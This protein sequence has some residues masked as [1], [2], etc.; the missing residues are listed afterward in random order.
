[1]PGLGQRMAQGADDQPADRP[2][3]AEPD[4]RLGRMDV[5][6][7]FG[8][9]N[10][11]K[12][13][14]ERMAV[15]GQEIAIGAAHGPGHQAILDRPAVD[16]EILVPRGSPMQRRHADMAGQ[17]YAV[18]HGV[19][20]HRIVGKILAQ[21]RREPRQPDIEHVPGVD[22]Q[23]KQGAFA[24]AAQAETDFRMRH[25]QPVDRVA[26]RLLLAALALEELEPRRRGVEQVEH[27]DLGAAGHRRRSGNAAQAAVN[28][29]RPARIGVRLPGR[30]L[31]PADR[32]DRRQRLAAEAEGRNVDEIVARQ[33]AGGVPLHGKRQGLAP[34][35][36]AVV[37]HGD[38]APAAVAHDRID[39][40]RTGVD[41]VLDQFLD[42]GR[43]AL[44]HLAR[45]NPVNN[46]WW[47][48]TNHS[49]N[50]VIQLSPDFERKS[51]TIAFAASTA[52]WV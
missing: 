24:V 7:H 44:D 16:E 19:D 11:E 15:A 13:G 22:R 50:N 1:M 17:P 25:R 41:R 23:R 10:I 35:A 48:E 37:G 3:I 52:G 49:P 47:K 46:I 30:D 5:H 27:L 2:G 18:A 42:D 33:L 6:V 45:G 28:V 29:D 12:Q 39:P 8:R 31:E 36:A 4:F 38:I 40:A 20:A 51:R 34:H 21:D 26:N 43:R 9:R 14:N 32:A